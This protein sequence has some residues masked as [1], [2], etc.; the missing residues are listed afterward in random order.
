VVRRPDEKN[1]I[2]SL[3]PVQLIQEERAVLI[4][5]QTIKVF[6]DD[7]TRSILSS[8]PEHLGNGVL[9]SEIV[10]GKGSFSALWY[11]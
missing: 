10:L 1:P 7:D 8:L 6:E 4:I 3:Q 5:D 11:R 2:I 9:F